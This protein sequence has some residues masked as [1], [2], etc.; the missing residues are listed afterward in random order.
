MQFNFKFG[1]QNK[2]AK[3][4]GIASLVGDF[5]QKVYKYVFFACLVAAASFGAYVWQRSLSGGSWSAEKKKEYIDSQSKKIFLMEGDYKKALV[6]IEARKNVGYEEV[7]QM[8]DIF[9][10]Y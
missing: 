10:E 7:S 6:D 9:K 5:W 8:R 2:T 3:Q 4:K 1:E